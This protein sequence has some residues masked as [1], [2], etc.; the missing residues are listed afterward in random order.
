MCIEPAGRRVLT[1][2]VPPD[3]SNRPRAVTSHFPAG[4]IRPSVGS[5]LVPRSREA[6]VLMDT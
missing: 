4:P 2:C 6:T 3:T 1:T 5:L